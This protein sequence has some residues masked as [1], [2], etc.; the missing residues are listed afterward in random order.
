MKRLGKVLV[1]FGAVVAPVAIGS[2]AAA[3]EPQ[4]KEQRVEVRIDRADDDEVP[5]DDD[6]VPPDDDKEKRER[7]PEVPGEVLIP[8]PRPAPAIPVKIAPRFTG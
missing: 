8:G 5:P 1:A 2:A 3:Q 7:R 6:D 4:Q